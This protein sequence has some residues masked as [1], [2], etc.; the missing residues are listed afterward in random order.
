VKCWGYNGHGQLGDGTTIN[1]SQP[2]DVSG[3]NSGVA[4][5]AAGLTHTC[6]LTREGGVKCWGDNWFAQ[7]GDG[8]TTRRLEPV[9]VPGLGSGVAGIAVGEVHTCALT[10]AGGVKCWGSNVAGQVGDGTH[11]P[12]TTPVDVI[13]L[14]E[15]AVGLSAGSQHTC[16]VTRNGGAKC[17]GYNGWGGLGDGTMTDRPSPTDVTNLS[18]GVAVIEAGGYKTCALTTTGGMKCWGGE[19]RLPGS[20]D[21]RPRDPHSRRRYGPDDRCLENLRGRSAQLRG[22]LRGWCEVLGTQ[23]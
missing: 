12:R 8:T 11:T 16:V 22:H 5:L 13:S 17:W 1:R 9:D 21:N 23:R 14:S 7:L 10:S 3:L 4:S 18:Q 19:L 2:V 20:R 15:G 6:A